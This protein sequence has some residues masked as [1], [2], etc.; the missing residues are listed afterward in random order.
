M[1]YFMVFTYIC[2][3]CIVFNYTGHIFQQKINLRGKLF[4]AILANS[5]L[6]ILPV[7]IADF[8]LDFLTMIL[9]FVIIGLEMRLFFKQSLVKLI[10]G[11]LSFAI[12]FFAIRVIIIAVLSLIND[13]SIN[14]YVQDIN[15]RLL[16]TTLNFLIP[17]PYVLITKKLLPGKVFELLLSSKKNLT[18]LV[19]MLSVTYLNQVVSTAVS[20]TVDVHIDDAKLMSYSQ[21]RTGIFALTTFII[22]MAS[23]HL[24]S[25]LRN[26]EIKFDTISKEIEKQ[27][28]IVEKL[29]VVSS[30]DAFT[31]FYIRNVAYEKIESYIDEK[32]EFFVLFIDL[33]GLKFVNDTHGHEEGDFYILSVS[34]ILKKHF[35]DDVKVRLGGDE[36]LIVGKLT[37]NNNLKST[38][39]L[40][41]VDIDNLSKNY[42]KTYNCSISSGLVIVPIDTKLTAKELIQQAD[43]K[44][45]NSKKLRKKA[46]DTVSILNL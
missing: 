40:V 42:N 38:L 41:N 10:L 11:V 22:M 19:I 28:T 8:K 43:E 31:G 29:K 20:L 9:Y 4:F 26:K 1:M 7:Y 21:I 36:F 44:M 18:F 30:V 16:I 6:I 34:E 25:G 23:V 3:N 27:E 17:I 14:V 45:Y 39:D 46:R 32:I 35:I 12:N 37:D 33:D 2:Y 24:F 5:F 13:V 15:A